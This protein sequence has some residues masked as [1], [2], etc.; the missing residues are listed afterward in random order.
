[1]RM[2]D[3]RL[4]EIL[5]IRYDCS[6]RE[7]DVV[8]IW[9]RKAVEIFFDDCIATVGNTILLQVS[10]THVR[11]DDLKVIRFLPLFFRN[12]QPA[13]RVLHW[14]TLAITPVAGIAATP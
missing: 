10:G 7:P 4:Y 13:C 11:G 12:N 1:M 14:S 5:R 8:G 2:S 3:E 6:H 9:V